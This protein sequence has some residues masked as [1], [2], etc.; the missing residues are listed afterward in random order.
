MVVTSL[1]EQIPLESYVKLLPSKVTLVRVPQ[2]EG[3]IR[4]RL[5]GAK[6]ARGQVL[7]FQDAH[8]ESN[9]GWAEPLLAEIARNPKVII[10]PEIDQIDA[11]TLVYT[12]GTYNVPRGG[13]SWDLRYEFTVCDKITVI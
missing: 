8:T 1:Y 3:L 6:L 12:A 9:V 7:F 13:F 5:I 4:A 11:Q 10:Q 2:R